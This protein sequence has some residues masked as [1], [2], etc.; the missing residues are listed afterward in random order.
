MERHALLEFDRFGFCGGSILGRPPVAPCRPT[1]RRR[2]E[3]IGMCGEQLCRNAST[4]RASDDV[5]PGDVQVVQEPHHI[6]PHLEAVALGV[7]GLVALAVSA[8]VERNDPV[9]R[10]QLREDTR[11]DPPGVE[12]VLSQISV[13][14]VKSENR[15][16]EIQWLTDAKTLEKATLRQNPRWSYTAERYSRGPVM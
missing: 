10:G 11:L 14:G 16:S 12:T 3:S 15:L 6:L 8:A 7:M 13:L 5:R 4:H 2:Q 1:E 9:V